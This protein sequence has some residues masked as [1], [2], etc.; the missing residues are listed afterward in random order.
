MKL[1]ADTDI[2]DIGV[3]NLEFGGYDFSY[4]LENLGIYF[5][6]MIF[7]AMLGVLMIILNTFKH[8]FEM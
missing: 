8:R 7:F 1:S 6:F 3:K 4:F 2:G 5:L